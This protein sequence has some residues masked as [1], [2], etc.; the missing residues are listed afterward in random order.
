M[1]IM[2]FRHDFD[3]PNQLQ[4]CIL[5]IWVFFV[6]PIRHYD[7]ESENLQ[8]QTHRWNFLTLQAENLLFEIGLNYNLYNSSIVIGRSSIFL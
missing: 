7:F 6:N 4:H 1:N 8:A 2:I 3:T 5:G